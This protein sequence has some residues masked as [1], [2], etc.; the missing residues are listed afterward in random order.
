MDK[1]WVIVAVTIICL[2]V[3]CVALKA[4]A[5][6]PNNVLALMDKAFV[7]MFALASGAS[8]GFVLGKK[9]TD[10]KKDT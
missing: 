4:P 6:V 5:G 10:K 8:V 3:L 9:S 7:G 2:S 1:V